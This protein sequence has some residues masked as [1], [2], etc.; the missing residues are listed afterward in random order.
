LRELLVNL[1]VPNDDRHILWNQAEKSV[2]V[3]K[4]STKLYLKVGSNTAYVNDVPVQLDVAPVNYSRNQRVYIPFRFVAATFGKKVVWDGS[5]NAILLRDA[6][7]YARIEEI[8]TKSNAAMNALKTYKQDM[9]IDASI[10]MGQVNMKMAYDISAEID[11]VKSV[12]HMNL[13]MNMLGMDLNSDSYYIDN[14]SYTLNPMTGKWEKQT[15]TA[16]QYKAAFDAEGNTDLLGANEA[17]YAGLVASRSADGS[18]TTLKGDVYLK[19]L[20]DKAMA[21]N[22][23]AKSMPGNQKTE[24][25]KFYMELVID[26]ATNL[27]KSIK[28]DISAEALKNAVETGVSGLNGLAAGATGGP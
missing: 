8:I 24:F 9:N 18:E 6:A 2:T 4:D 7:E 1:G 21:E 28:M 17:L 20:F 23:S 11:K 22:S 10:N 26:N 19:G 14:A 16:E 25:D 15:Y 5:A 27:I 13:K 3:Y 12:M